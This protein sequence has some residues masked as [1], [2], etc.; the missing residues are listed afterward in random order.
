MYQGASPDSECPLVVDAST[1][2]C[3]DSRFGC[4]VCTMVD[5]DRSMRA[6]IQNDDEKEWMRPLLDLRSELGNKNDRELRDFRRLSGAVQLF[7]DRPIHGPYR[8]DIRERWLSKLLEAQQWIREN[9]P[10][11]AKAM[12]LIT[13]DEMQEIRRIWI[14]EKHEIEDNV[15]RIY[16]EVV[17][18]KYPGMSIDEGLV[19]SADD[20]NILRELCDGDSIFFELTRELIDVERMFYKATRRAGLY[21]ALE[22]AF[23]RGFYS[24][25]E[26][27]TKR[28]KRRRD[29]TV[30]AKDGRYL[31]LSLINGIEQD[32]KRG[33]KKKKPK[34]AS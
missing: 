21:N 25:E 15:P 16:E 13:L 20:V 1:P 30:A 8:Q 14:T 33:S 17:N 24:D 27:A 18:E 26:D 19:F 28:A 9:G 7:H 29:A 31:Q 12:E 22:Q 4:W 5:E 10:P 34:G 32:K 2:S 3:G 6:M 23:L 11:E